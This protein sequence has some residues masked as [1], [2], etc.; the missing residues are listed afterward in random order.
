MFASNNLVLTSIPIRLAH[1]RANSLTNSKCNRSSNEKAK[2]VGASLGKD[3]N[4]FP[5]RNRVSVGKFVKSW[6]AL[7]LKYL[8]N[9]VKAKKM[10][11]GQELGKLAKN[12]LTSKALSGSSP[13]Y[14]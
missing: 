14:G 2:G 1:A 4:L 7:W 9:L 3:Q 11:S 10:Q 5:S 8:S 13:N 12:L 6:S